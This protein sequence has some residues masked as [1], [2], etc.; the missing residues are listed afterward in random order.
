MALTNPNLN[1]NALL[2][3]DEQDAVWI[4]LNTLEWIDL[5]LINDDDADRY[6]ATMP[7]WA[8]T[9]I[10]ECE[11]A[12]LLLGGAAFASST[13]TIKKAN[14]TSYIPTTVSL[15]G[16]Q[17][18][19]LNPI[20][21]YGFLEPASTGGGGVLDSM[22]I[23]T[24]HDL[25]YIGGV[26]PSYLTSLEAEDT[27]IELID[28]PSLPS[29][30]TLVNLRNN[31]I[32]QA[33]LDYLL[34]LLVDAGAEGGTLDISGTSQGTPSLAGLADLATLEGRGWTVIYND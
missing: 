22:L 25:E 30:L 5:R 15:Y 1:R 28:V 6:R 27:G 19:N 2:V 26:L 9:V 20:Y 32:P 21:R 14:D 10:A 17:T 29:T 23:N 33:N 8:E 4:D 3:S 12:Y 31:F 11:Q 18:P 7:N 34:A 16:S 24:T 13:I